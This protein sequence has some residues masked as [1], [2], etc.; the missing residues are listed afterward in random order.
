MNYFQ[1]VVSELKQVTWPKPKETLKMSGIVLA[2]VIVS[3]LLI[4]GLDVGLS[5]ALAWFLGK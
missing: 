3:T 1:G 5:S 4:W 2:V